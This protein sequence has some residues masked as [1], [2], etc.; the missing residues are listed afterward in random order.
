M[1]KKSVVIIFL[2]I[3]GAIASLYGCAPKVVLEPIPMESPHD[4][5]TKAEKSFET[6]AYAEA[7]A[8][9]ESYLNKFPDSPMAPGAL[10]KMG[11]IK[12][13]QGD[14]ETARIYFERILTEYPDTVFFSDAGVEVLEMLFAQGRF[15]DLIHRATDLPKERMNRIQEVRVS[16]L[17]GDSFLSMDL[18][19]EAVYSYM[20][21]YERA[22]TT[23]R[24]TIETKIRTAL[25]KLSETQ[26][27]ELAD[28]LKDPALRALVEGPRKTTAFNREIIGCL[29][30]LSGQY[31][32]FGQRAL[33]G[34]ELAMHQF[35]SRGTTQYKMIVKDAQSE[36]SSSVK[37]VQELFDEN[38]SCIIG[39]MVE[40]VPA[41]KKA[42][43][44]QIPIVALSQKE[45]IPET[46]DYVFRNFITPEMQ[47]NTL[48]SYAMNELGADRFIVLYP[49]EK[50]GTTFMNLFWE[51]VVK[52][53]GQMVGSE[54]YNPGQTDFEDS[55]KRLENLFRYAPRGLDSTEAASVGR[56]ITANTGRGYEGFSN[57]GDSEHIQYDKDG[58]AFVVRPSDVL[59]IPDSSK[60]AGLIIPQLAYHDVNN[61]IIM[62][63]NLW[64]SDEL[65]KMAGPYAQG[66]LITDGF[67]EQSQ[68][69]QVREFVDAFERI[70]GS[71]PGF[72]EAIAYDTAMMLFKVLSN[73]GI[74]NRQDIRDN[75]QK[76]PHYNGVTGK[77]A[78]KENGD[79]EKELFLLELRNDKFIEIRS[80]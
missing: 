16:I 61:V 63:T 28:R 52:Q 64:H 60:F 12:A 71:K 58:N 49:R 55:L 24:E 10:M 6:G 69:L 66:A 78:F 50:Y 37:G 74:R 18:P 42:Q 75:L 17:V 67:F 57:D 36:S 2:L 40:P 43:E 23:E 56:G 13:W 45:G 59:F 27:R 53:N 62:G 7:W 31:K 46:G 35:G 29:L 5:F 72:F 9:Y 44:L 80:F 65:I 4:L 11:K 70:Y 20:H 30:P 76:M 15:S 47:V 26:T 79:V 34:I 25:S 68:S 19:M 21:G 1:K 32:E 14:Y 33:R 51:E 48:V 73:P 54:P 3:W 77:T 8:Q 41:V 39:P 22:S 38:A